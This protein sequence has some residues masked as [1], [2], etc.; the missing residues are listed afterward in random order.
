MNPDK[1]TVCGIE[2]PFPWVGLSVGLIV[3][4][5]LSALLS[6][7]F[8]TGTIALIEKIIDDRPDF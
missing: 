7:G 2:K 3:G 6:Y 5:T 1:Y 8:A 4:A